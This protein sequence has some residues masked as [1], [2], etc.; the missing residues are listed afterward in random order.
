MAMTKLETELMFGQGR[1]AGWS[2]SERAIAMRLPDN[3]LAVLRMFPQMAPSEGEAA[4]QE[5]NAATDIERRRVV[6][7]V[8]AKTHDEMLAS[9]LAIQR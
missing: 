9:R 5:A 3:L 8:G 7:S 6:A 1:W 2:E 4:M